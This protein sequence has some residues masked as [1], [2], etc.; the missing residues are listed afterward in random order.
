MK[1]GS[2]YKWKAG[3]EVFKAPRIIEYY[4]AIT[5]ENQ[6]DL[7]RKI[8]QKFGIYTGVSFLVVGLIFGIIIGV[9]I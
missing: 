7:A 4:K 9:I 8:E 5:D 3:E 6:Y 2:Y 1:E